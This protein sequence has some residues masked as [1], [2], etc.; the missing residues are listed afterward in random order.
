MVLFQSIFLKH[1]VIFLFFNAKLKNKYFK[2]NTVYK[3]TD[4]IVLVLLLEF[5]YLCMYFTILIYL[6]LREQLL[7][8]EQQKSH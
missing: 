1:F 8:V 2:L 5:H 4:D 7:V 3:K 6:N